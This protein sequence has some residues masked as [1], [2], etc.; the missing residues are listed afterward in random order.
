M[1]I[2]EVPDRP[3]IAA[4][5]FR[6]LADAGVNVDMIV[7]NVSE[8]GRTDVSF[9]LPKHDLADGGAGARRRSRARSAG[10]ASQR[11]RR[12]RRSRSSAP[13]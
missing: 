4:A 6:P 5:I 2:R 7:Q 9:T 3:G 1:T 11:T 13:A 10:T 12:W 8:E